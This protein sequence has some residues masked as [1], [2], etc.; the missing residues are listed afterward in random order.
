M[1]AQ[2]VSSVEPAHATTAPIR[3]APNPRAAELPL[4]YR[5]L[6]QHTHTVWTPGTRTAAAVSPGPP[7]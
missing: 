7:R 4:C 3:P 5:P 2:A 1:A 6:G